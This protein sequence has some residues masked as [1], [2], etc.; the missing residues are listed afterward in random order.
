[1]T[2][3]KDD[4]QFHVELA[5]GQGREEF[6]AATGASRE[7]LERLDRYATFV[8]EW[9]Q[10]FNLIAKSTLPTLWT[11]HFLD[12]WQVLNFIPADASSLAD[13]G[14]GAGF[15]G[16]VLACFGLGPIHLIESTGKKAKFLAEVA[17]ELKLNVK[18]HNVRAED[19]KDLKVD[20]VTARAVTAL[21]DLLKLA[22]RLGKASTTY[23]FPKG[24]KADAE[25]T[26]SKKNWTFHSKKTTSMT[27]DS[28]SVLVITNLQW[29]H[30]RHARKHN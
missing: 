25:L 2:L 20:V 11:R 5:S 19:I 10:R 23:I 17:M 16:L 12:S 3:T 26:E 1:M 27:D 18:V 4:P 15:P 9:N 29:K 8:R 13:I 28:A 21:P 7:T 14:A 6:V 30:A 22:H 24:E